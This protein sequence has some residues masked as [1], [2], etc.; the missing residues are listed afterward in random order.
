MDE[1]FK[2]D[3]S[4]EE[5]VRLRQNLAQTGIITDEILAHMNLSPE[6]YKNIIKQSLI[7]IKS[8]IIDD[9]ITG[10]EQID[11]LL[12]VTTDFDRDFFD[13][14]FQAIVSG[15]EELSGIASKCVHKIIDT[16]PTKI[17]SLYNIEEILGIL[18]SILDTPM[19]KQKRNIFTKV[20]LSA[21]ETR[22]LIN[23]DFAQPF[24]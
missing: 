1:E 21:T 24:D 13:N 14:A 12:E 9:K 6:T 20:I 17:Q 5:K 7:Q 3:S 11:R 19:T 15:D 18:S 23:D 10:Y 2:E 22:N 8:K 4:I 16:S